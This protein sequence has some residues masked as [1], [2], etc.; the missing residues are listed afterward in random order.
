MTLNGEQLE[1]H[2]LCQATILGVEQFPNERVYI[3]STQKCSYRIFLKKK[4]TIHVPWLP[5]D[6]A[7]ISSLLWPAVDRHRSFIHVAFTRAFRIAT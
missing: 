7:F 5:D 3:T 1:N 2:M 6:A 4:K